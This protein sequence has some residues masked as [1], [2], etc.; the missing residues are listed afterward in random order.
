[1]QYV[2]LPGML[3]ICS[4]LIDQGQNVGNSFWGVTKI[5]DGEDYLIREPYQEMHVV[6]P[7]AEEMTV[8][9]AKEGPY[10]MIHWVTGKSP[11]EIFSKAYLCLC[12]PLEI[13]MRYKS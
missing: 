1:M 7:E 8:I 4:S 3:S 9:L 5:I 13:F 10:H 12:L 11:W 2:N 6:K